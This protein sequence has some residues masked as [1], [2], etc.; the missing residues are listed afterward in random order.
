MSQPERASIRLAELLGV[1][2]L[3]TDLGMG[4]PMEHILRQCLISM[5]L[6]QVTAAGRPRPCWRTTGSRPT[7]WRR[8]E[9]ACWPARPR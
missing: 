4:Q 8:R 1:L 3:G 2:S 7:P 9:S 6:A 5:R